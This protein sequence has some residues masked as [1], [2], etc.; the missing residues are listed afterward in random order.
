[1]LSVL[2]LIHYF[3]ILGSESM[4]LTTDQQ[5]HLIYYLLTFLM[6]IC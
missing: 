3:L 5:D 6:G 2:F 1:M 4:A